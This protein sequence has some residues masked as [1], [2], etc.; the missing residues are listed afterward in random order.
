MFPYVLH[1]AVADRLKISFEEQE[2]TKSLQNQK[3]P[4]NNWVFEIYAGGYAEEE[5][6]KGR[7]DVRYGFYATRVTEDWKI[8]ARPYFNHNVRRF[9]SSDAK[10]R[11]VSKRHG[12][13]GYLIRSLTDH[14]S[15]GLFGDILSSTFSN[16]DLRVELA[17]AVEYSLF[18]YS[19]SSRKEITFRFL[20]LGG[21]YNYIEETLFDKNKEF[22]YRQAFSAT[23]R[24]EQ[25]WGSVSSELEGSHFL[26]DLQKNRLEFSS[27]IRL[28]VVKG[29]QI[30][31]SGG[32]RDHSR[33]SLPGKRR[34]L[35]GRGFTPA[36]AIGYYL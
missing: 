11:S 14:W 18:P 24:F 23:V 30:D 20:L 5:A 16:M 4:W 7:L 17:P 27:R 10:I 15:T 8:R 34:C 2:R 25:P 9:E 36:K 31:F 1:T 6:S 13:E 19:M 32:C 26:H 29:L 22:L 35:A 3:D 21:Y 33:P 28:R 12:F